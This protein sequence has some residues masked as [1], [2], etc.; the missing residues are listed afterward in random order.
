MRLMPVML[1]GMLAIIGLGSVLSGLYLFFLT[2]D[3]EPKGIKTPV[4]YTDG[5]TIKGK[6]IKEIP[7]DPSIFNN[8]A[9]YQGSLQKYHSPD[10]TFDLLKHRFTEYQKQVWKNECNVPGRLSAILTMSAGGILALCF[11]ISIWL[12]RSRR[13]VANLLNVSVLNLALT[14]RSMEMAFR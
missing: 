9:R 5:P 6:S 10:G 7:L 2:K 4:W 3:K 14:Y 8:S 11:L 1:M 12:Y 13:C